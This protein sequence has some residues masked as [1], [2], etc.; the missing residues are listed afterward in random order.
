[1]G[2]LIIAALAVLRFFDDD[3]PF[4][5]RSMFFL[6]TGIG[7]FVANYLVIKRKKSLAIKQP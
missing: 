2:L 1:M 4:V 7:F 3:I 6:A 5:W